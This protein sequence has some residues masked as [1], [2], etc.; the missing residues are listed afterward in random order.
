MAVGA[1]YINHTMNQINKIQQGQ[2]WWVALPEQTHPQPILVVQGNP[3]NQ[4]MLQTAVCVPLDLN[5]RLAEAP[6]NVLLSQADTGLPRSCVANISHLITI[7]KQFLGKYVG[8]LSSYVLESV[9]DG[10]QLLFGR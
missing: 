8:T 6:G 1:A 10:V 7:D 3:F 2:I 9:L 5:W 4:S